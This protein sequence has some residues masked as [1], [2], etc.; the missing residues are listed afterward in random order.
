[1]P[2]L[3]VKGGKE[4]EQ[5][6]RKNIGWLQGSA[7]TIGAVLGSGVLVLPS[8]AADMA[9]PASLISWVLMASGI[10]S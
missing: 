3:T 1:M 8:L 6:F 5:K 4:M 7:M 2:M 10:V 9:G